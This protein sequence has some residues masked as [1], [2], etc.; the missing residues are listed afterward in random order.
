MKSTS[1]ISSCRL[2]RTIDWANCIE[3]GMTDIAKKSVFFLQTGIDDR[4]TFDESFVEKNIG[5]GAM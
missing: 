1:I 5:T 4:G 2:A 3:K